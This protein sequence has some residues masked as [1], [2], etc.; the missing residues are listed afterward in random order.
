M[1]K[2][3]P[4]SIDG[5][6]GRLDSRWHGSGT[7]VLV[8]HPHPKHGGTM[9]TRLVYRICDDLSDAGYLAV[10]F[11]FR[12]AG[13]SD[14]AY[15]GGDGETDDALAMW[16]A[17]AREHGPAAVVGFS[18]G[19][20]VAVRVAAQREVPALVLVSTP[21]AVRDSELRPLEEAARVRCPSHVIVGTD[22][23]LV[24]PRD[25]DAVRAVLGARITFLQGADHFLTP[26]HHDRA[27][28]AV[29][30]ALERLLRAPES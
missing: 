23:E 22:D 8:L 3:K 9:G 13:R 1:A 12:G 11:D 25:A 4:R 2:G 29:S 19:G 16:D 24:D 27:V 28:H 26:E 30:S 5:P 21:A 10:R 7:P 18:F 20:G 15:D 17:L 6:A 14:G